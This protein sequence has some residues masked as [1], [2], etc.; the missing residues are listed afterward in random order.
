M[1]SLPLYIELDLFAAIMLVF[2]ARKVIGIRSLD[3]HTFALMA[4]AQASVFVLDALDAA[5]QL[6]RF[7]AFCVWIINICFFIWTMASVYLWLRFE[8]VMITHH[9]FSHRVG[10]LLSIPVAVTA[11]LAIS[12]P[13]T[14][15]LFTVNDEHIYVRGPLYFIQVILL[16]GYFALTIIYSLVY[17]YRLRDRQ[18]RRQTYALSFFGFAAF[19]AGALDTHFPD[20]NFLC[21]ALTLALAYLVFHFWDSFVLTDRDLLKTAVEYAFPITVYADLSRDEYRIIDMPSDLTGVL[22]PAGQYSTFLNGIAEHIP[23]EERDAFTSV[24]N[25]DHMMSAFYE[26]SK[27]I[28]ARYRIMQ[29][30]GLLHWNDIMSVFISNPESDGIQQIIL[31]KNTDVEMAKELQ[32]REARRSAEAANSAKTAFL[33]N[34]SHDIRTPMNAIIGFTSMAESHLNDPAKVSDCLDKVHISSDHLLKLINDILDM[35]RIESGN[36]RIDEQPADLSRCGDE[37]SDIVLNSASDHGLEFKVEYGELRDASVY[38]DTLRVNQI[39]LNIVSNSIKYTHSGGHVLLRIEQLTGRHQHYGSYR[40]TISDDGI[41]MSPDF[42]SHIF[43]L[44]SRERSTTESGIEGTGLGMA[45]TKQL[46]DAMGGS[47]H[48]ESEPGAGTT[49]TIELDFRLCDAD[50]SQPEAAETFDP[51]V[52]VGKRILLVEDNE[53]NREIACEIL[54]T[55]SMQVD[56]AE[57][58]QIAVN[59]VIS[60]E[61]V[62]DIILMDIQMPVMDGYEATARIRSLPDAERASIPIIAM[63]ANAFDEDRRRS[64]AAGMNDHLA[65]PVQTDLMLR[66]IA[67]YV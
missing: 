51:A 22:E 5:S 19:I 2:F 61:S 38:A 41:G 21:V 62:Y 57:N 47:I 48:V 16:F 4:Y 52:L 35:A 53:L 27:E 7:P 37:I 26:G 49:V 36:I 65:K 6:V 25:I 13:V 67:K 33:F 60:S 43:D 3:R 8:R 20:M 9:P 17:G 45:I 54:E 24:C 59:K 1:N 40:F 29:E 23:V 11:V 63:T 42:V 14:G 58:G 10:T 44:F 31:I 28:T 39:L 32:L 56:S 30:D 18:R 46:I 55:M 64:F 34:M 15:W 12:S 66:T 50:A